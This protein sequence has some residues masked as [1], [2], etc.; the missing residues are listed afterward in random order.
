M[1]KKYEKEKETLETKIQELQKEKL[2]DNEKLEEV[3]ADLKQ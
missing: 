2:E 3:A 1:K